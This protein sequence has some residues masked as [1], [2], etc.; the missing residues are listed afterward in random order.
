MSEIR[1][2]ES[3]ARLIGFDTTSRNSNRGLI[4]YARETLSALGARIR[5]TTDATGEK[6]N[7]FATLGPG[8]APGLLLSGHTDTVPVD[9]QSWSGDPFTL[10]RDGDRLVGRGVV[11]MKGFLA[12]VLAKLPGMM[13]A[14]PAATF[15]LAMSF[16]EEVGCLGVPLLIDDM[17]AAGIRPLACIVGEPTGMTT[18]VA[19]KGKIGC[20]VTVRGRAAHT[21]VP[22]LGVNAI[23]AAA[24]AIAWLAAVAARHR[25]HG[26]YDLLFDEPPYT[27]IQQA[28]VSGGIAVNTVPDLCTYHFDIRYLPRVDPLA[29]VEGLVAY[30]RREIEPA[31]KRVDPDAGLNFAL[32]PGCEAFDTPTHEPIVLLVAALTGEKALRKV[33]FGTEAGHFAKAGIP[34]VVCG[35]GA[36]SEAHRADESLALADV[37][38]C[39]R[40]LDDL[41]GRPFAPY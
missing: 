13:R 8:D 11:D 5:I 2:L 30:A 20:G 41:A 27:T 9:G 33:G 6:Q 7:L 28:L 26:P 35:P 10:R 14:A 31:M 18:V 23:E 37:A 19:Q 1:S 29:I 24:G 4:D 36:I 40:F 22:H 16:D 21:G 34:T 15:H 17:L 3:I 32:V 38:R 39:E 12:I 25:E